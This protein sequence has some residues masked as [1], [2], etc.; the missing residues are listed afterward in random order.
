MSAS[1]A[2]GSGSGAAA[3]LSS[4]LRRVRSS[5]EAKLGDEE[6]AWRDCEK[7]DGVPPAPHRSHIPK[8]EKQ[9][10]N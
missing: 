10:K 8:H 9:T 7:L 6:A 2:S 1:A 5:L 4:F 3:L